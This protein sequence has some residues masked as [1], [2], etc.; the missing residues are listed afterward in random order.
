M[1][2]LFS[3]DEQDVVG[4]LMN[5]GVGRAAGAFSRLVND[6]VLL[7]VPEV[8]FVGLAEAEKVFAS[9]VPDILAGVKQSFSGF[10]GGSAALLFPEDRSLELVRAIIGEDLPAEEISE[11]EQETLAEVGNIILN[12]CLATIAN[13]LQD[14]IQTSLPETY[15]GG[16]RGFLEFLC[17]GALDVS[18]GGEGSGSLLMLVQ[19]DFSLK[20][21]AIQGFLAFAIDLRA[22]ESFRQ[23]IN[24]YLDSLA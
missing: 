14:E 13:V 3:P 17:N 21:R 9:T 2:I 24:A 11:L 15:A 22:A 6:E 18:T 8:S 12:N 7:S 10:I 4:E 5:L 20:R 16:T 23:H 1:T 19:I